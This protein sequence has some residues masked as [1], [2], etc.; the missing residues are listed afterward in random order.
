MSR[1]S[2]FTLSCTVDFPDDII[3]GP[4]SEPL[5]DKMMQKMVSMG[6][7]RIFWNFYENE[8][9]DRSVFRYGYQTLSLIGEPVKAAVPVA[10]KHG[11]EI[12]AGI[13]PFNAGTSGSFPEGS[14][15]ARDRTLSC[16]GGKIAH[17]IAVCR[18]S[19]GEEDSQAGL[20]RVPGPSRGEDPPHQERR[21]AH[22]PAAGKPGDLDEPEQLSLRTQ[23][24]RVLA[25]GKCA[26]RTT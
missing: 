4:Y 24:H 20:R 2:N 12:Y 13:K 9:F 3:Y 16:I 26:A 14:P 7:K 15:D 17:A 25:R 22:A 18:K 8:I 11:L 23:T 6:V 21:H 19:P 5:L 10:H 1:N